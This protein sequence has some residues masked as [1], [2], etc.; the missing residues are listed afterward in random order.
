[1]R[2]SRGLASRAARDQEIDTGFNLPRDEI[3][4]RGVIDRAV[5]MKRSDQSSAASTKLHRDTVAR[6]SSRGKS[7]DRD[8]KV[9]QG[10]A[11]L[12]FGFELL[13]LRTN[14]SSWPSSALSLSC[15]SRS[16]CAA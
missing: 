2:E 8:H 6:M 9:N 11:A 5:L 4:E 12:S 3:T 10:R 16:C 7:R 1:M 13:P 14:S 15:S